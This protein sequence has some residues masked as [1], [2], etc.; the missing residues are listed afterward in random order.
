MF[1]NVSA[2]LDCNSAVV[3]TMAIRSCSHLILDVVEPEFEHDRISIV[4]PGHGLVAGGPHCLT[5]HG[6][7]KNHLQ[8][9]QPGSTRVE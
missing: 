6:A 9:V 7:R 1:G 2:Y 8:N 3:H 5:V 4:V